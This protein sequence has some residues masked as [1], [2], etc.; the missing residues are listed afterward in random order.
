MSS[1]GAFA[2]V[3]AMPATSDEPR[4]RGHKKKERTRRQLLD[5]AIDVIADR[6][7]AFTVQ[8]V[9]EQAGVSNGTFYNYFEDR[10]QLIDAVLPE[11]FEA[12]VLETAEEVT[13]DDPAVR[14][15]TMSTRV[16]ERAAAE[17]HTIR[18]MLRLDGVQRAILDGSGVLDHLR[19]DLDEGSDQGRFSFE[20]TQAM[21][22]IV[23]GALL[24][25]ARRIADQPRNAR[26]QT[27]VVAGL[28]RSL[29]I[30]ATEARQLADAAAS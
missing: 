4:T 11:V 13:H 9:A 25:A 22:D 29:G 5:A 17:Q 10:D 30:T 8:H 15:A 6:G 21:L 20:E 3:Q 18:A 23:I 19:H 1:P 12:F 27:Q 14:F 24:L 7:E 26:Y 28:L 2:T 16:L